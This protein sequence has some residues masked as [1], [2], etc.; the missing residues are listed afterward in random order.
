MAVMALT[1][2][3]YLFLSIWSRWHIFIGISTYHGPVFMQYVRM[4]QL[5]QKGE[6]RNTCFGIQTIV[7]HDLN[8]Q[9]ETT[10]TKKV[11][12]V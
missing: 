9:D 12:S 6:L 7:I 1:R 3:R 10:P 4:E 8:S 11:K 2:F 5:K